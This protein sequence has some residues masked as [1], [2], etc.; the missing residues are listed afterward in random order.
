VSG[1]R[2]EDRRWAW[3][4]RRAELRYWLPDDRPWRFALDLFIAGQTLQ[5]TGPVTISC[6]INVKLLGSLRADEPREYTFEKP[7]P[8]SWVGPGAPVSVVI[9][10]D[11]AKVSPNGTEFAFLLVSAGFLPQ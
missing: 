5:Q 8:A 4:S 7:V 10:T 1:I 9:E 6:Y 11:K 2:P 3:T